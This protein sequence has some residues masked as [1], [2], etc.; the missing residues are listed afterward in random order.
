MF[1]SIADSCAAVA[2]AQS[3]EY[4]CTPSVYA[5]VARPWE[6]C[7]FWAACCAVF[8]R[9]VLSVDCGSSVPGDDRTDSP[10]ARLVFQARTSPP[11]TRRYLLKM[12]DRRRATCRNCGV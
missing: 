7:Q 12:P 6:A 5:C 9:R 10:T 11:E 3:P 1:V 2:P 4:A 8:T